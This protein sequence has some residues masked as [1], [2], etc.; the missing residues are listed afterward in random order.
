MS[1]NTC[2]IRCP[3]RTTGS[4]RIQKKSTCT[5]GSCANSTR[6]SSGPICSNSRNTSSRSRPMRST[7][8][9][10]SV[11]CRTAPM[12]KAGRS[13]RAITSIRIWRRSGST[14]RRSEGAVEI[15]SAMAAALLSAAL[16][17]VPAAAAE[18][19]RY[20]GTLNFMIPADAPP[21]F[22][23]HREATF[24]TVHSAAP[25]YSVLIRAN[26]ENPSSTID[27]VCDLCTAMPRPTDG[28]KTYTFKI[29]DG[30]KF[31]D[32]STLT[33]ADV[34]ASWKKI[35][36]P[37]E[38]SISPRQSNFKMV[39][40]VEAPDPSTVIFRLKFAT[41]AFLP[42]L[43]D[44]YAWIYKRAILD[45][46]PRWYEKNILG[47]GPFKFVN[48]DTGQSIKGERN[49]DYYHRGLP[50]LDGFT[51]IFAEKQAVR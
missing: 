35:I 50:Y 19:P 34:A 30:V 3:A 43:A 33:A 28:G 7:C 20:G 22:D 36:D 39:D 15:R 18:T 1:V 4:S 14:N 21:S 2:R 51:G 17:A 48:Y 8:C 6:P 31:A 47:S 46:D 40:K 5:T 37:P 25:F 26:P 29:R 45:K 13:G 27:L 12:S 9:G 23:G 16:F 41:D 32:G 49:P 24:A 42:A 11:S 44:P 38:G 10:G